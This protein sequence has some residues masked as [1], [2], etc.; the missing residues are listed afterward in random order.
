MEELEKTMAKLQTMKH[1]LILRKM[2]LFNQYFAFLDSE[3]Y[4]ADSLFILHKVRVTFCAEYQH[5]DKPYR[6][7]LC[8]CRKKDIEGFLSAM[9]ELPRKMLICGHQD[10]LEVSEE[11]SRTAFGDTRG[12]PESA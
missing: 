6:V 5:K 2:S 1:C 3:D 7:I 10:Y 9:V 11:L 8:R 12:V 4:L